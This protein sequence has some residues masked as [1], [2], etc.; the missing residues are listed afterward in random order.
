VMCPGGRP[1][2]VDGELRVAK[3]QACEGW[4]GRESAVD[5]ELDGATRAALS[6]AWLVDAQLEHASVAAF[7]RLTL[8]LMALGAPAHLVRES[9]Q[10]SLDEIEH[11]ELCFGLASRYGNRAFGP[12]DLELQGALDDL[13]LEALLTSSIEEGCIGETVAA[14]MAG[15]QASVA[16]DARAKTALERIT[17]DETRHSAL[18]W[19]IVRWVLERQP[20]LQHT[21]RSTFERLLSKRE[22]AAALSVRIDST[23]FRAHG[24]LSPEDQASV[25]EEAIRCVI[26]PC[27]DRLLGEEHTESPP[28]HA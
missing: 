5:L 27:L 8:Q 20:S 2:R 9:Q 19:R 1:F 21:A 12:G 24:R 15:E 25:R 26:R 13:S 18:A 22:P 3:V 16:L 28:S 11:A 14:M 17:R 23:A 4:G 7:A 10:A 6:R